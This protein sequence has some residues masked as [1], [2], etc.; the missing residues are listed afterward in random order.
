MN[1]DVWSFLRSKRRRGARS[2]TVAQLAVA[3]GVTETEAQA[4][5]ERATELG[6]LRR[7]RRDGYDEYRITTP[8]GGAP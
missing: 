3:A 2:F 5:L 4:A 6:Y 8:P 1:R 7:T